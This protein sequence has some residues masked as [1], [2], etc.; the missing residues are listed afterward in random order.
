MLIQLG[1]FLIYSTFNKRI[2][3]DETRFGYRARMIT[4]IV[5]FSYI[6]YLPYNEQCAFDRIAG[7]MLE[8][9]IEQRVYIKL[10]RQV[11]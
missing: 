10:P 1:L 7:K 4:R 3:R 5:K 6:W 8:T 9:K 11:E 2:F